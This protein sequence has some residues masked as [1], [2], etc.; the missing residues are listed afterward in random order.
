[1][2]VCERTLLFPEN[3]KH[4]SDTDND[5]DEDC[6]CEAQL[7]D[8]VSDRVELVLE[9]RLLFFD[10][11]GETSTALV[12]VVTDSKNDGLT[13]AIFDQRTLQKVRT[14]IVSEVLI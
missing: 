7:A 11:H 6:D 3:T 4:G 13:G 9:R 2:V 12:G 10:V 8:L 1:M 14:W 5:E